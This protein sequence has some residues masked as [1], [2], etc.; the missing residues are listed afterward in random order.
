MQV[1]SP[2]FPASVGHASRVPGGWGGCGNLREHQRTCPF[3]HPTGSRDGCPT[4][5]TEPGRLWGT[6]P[7]CRA[8]WVGAEVHTNIRG[9]ALS[10]ARPAAGT[11]APQPLQSRADCGAR[12]PRAGRVGSAAIVPGDSPSSLGFRPVLVARSLELLPEVA[13]DAAHQIQGDD[14]ENGDEQTEAHPAMVAV[15]VGGRKVSGAPRSLYTGTGI[16]DGF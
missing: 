12:V 14:H 15:R 11:A 10:T 4:I 9:T 3:N 1:T 8:G 16:P 2:T 7:A 5:A 6:R 13:E